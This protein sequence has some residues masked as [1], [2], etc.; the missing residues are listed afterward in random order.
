MLSIAFFRADGIVPATPTLSGTISSR[1]EGAMTAGMSRP[2]S[3]FSYHYAHD[4]H[5]YDL[6]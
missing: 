2:A 1:F 5:S 6:R 4:S 3:R